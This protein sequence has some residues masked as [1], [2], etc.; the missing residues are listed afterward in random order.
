MEGASGNRARGR[1]PPRMLRSQRARRRH[2]PRN[3]APGQRS[4]FNW[5]I[6]FEFGTTL[7]KMIAIRKPKAKNNMR[8][9]RLGVPAGRSDVILWPM[10]IGVKFVTSALTRLGTTTWYKSSST[11][12]MYDKATAL[13]RRSGMD[14][15]YASHKA[16]D[17]SR[18]H[19]MASCITPR[20]TAQ[21]VNMRV[22]PSILNSA[23]TRPMMRA[24]PLQDRCKCP[25]AKVKSRAPRSTSV[26]LNVHMKMHKTASKGPV[27][28]G[29][30]GS[31]GLVNSF[32]LSY[33]S[34]WKLSVD[35]V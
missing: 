16:P 9:A 12:M 26:T 10:S 19:P 30:N 4:F 33:K 31:H 27:S 11:C 20:V 29:K 8:N 2:T 34:A 22:T 3:Y 35:K 6:L 17:T 25:Q 13:A 14:F 5:R 24:S 7:P 21:A 1:A 15:V 32:A 23:P 18:E 28:T